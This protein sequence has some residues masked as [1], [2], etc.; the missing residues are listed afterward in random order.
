MG[1]FYIW[2]LIFGFNITIMLIFG[3]NITIPSYFFLLPILLYFLSFQI[4]YFLAINNR[5]SVLVQEINSAIENQN[6]CL[7]SAIHSIGSILS[8]ISYVVIAG[9][10]KK[11]ERDQYL[12]LKYK[13]KREFHFLLLSL[14]S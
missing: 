9:Q 13:R 2:L 12:P 11:Q 10:V 14:N 8:L 7:C 6:L 4:E 5:H 1:L 3:F